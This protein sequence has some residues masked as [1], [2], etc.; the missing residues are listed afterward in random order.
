MNT[1]NLIDVC[2]EV[3][4]LEKAISDLEWE[5]Q[6]PR[7]EARELEYFRSLQTKGIQWEPLF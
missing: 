4:R 6:D 5:G 7:F 3:R 2:K 1:R